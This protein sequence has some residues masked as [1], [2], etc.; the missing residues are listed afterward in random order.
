MKQRKRSSAAIPVAAAISLAFYL[1]G[2][3]ASDQVSTDPQE[4]QPVPERAAE[5]PS[6]P[7]P[8]GPFRAPQSS[9]QDTHRMPVHMSGAQSPHTRRGRPEIHRGHLF[10]TGPEQRGGSRQ[11]GPATAFQPGSPPPWVLS[12][13]DRTPAPG[14]GQQPP[15]QSPMVSRQG[16]GETATPPTAGY[17]PRQP[18]WAAP[19][20]T[21]ATPAWPYNMPSGINR[22][23]PGRD[24][25]FPYGEPR[26]AM[27]ATNL[28]P[29]PW[30]PSPEEVGREQPD[31][32]H[33]RAAYVAPD[34]A[35]PPPA[36]APPTY[37]YPGQ[38]YPAPGGVSS[39][40][41]TAPGY[42]GY[43]PWGGYGYSRPY[44]APYPYGSAPRNW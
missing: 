36:V 8:P 16:P 1:A 42:Y 37:P 9:A 5:S 40:P 4:L 41:G 38:G 10:G 28:P 33:P 30:A 31:T 15:P 24:I 35:P 23:V 39:Q 21:A 34:F 12:D 29:S 6:A 32:G 19:P 20:A 26:Q 3:S 14:A 27:P 22:P 17:F 2:V 43:A 44:P 18:G 25:R 13:A 7:P 11:G